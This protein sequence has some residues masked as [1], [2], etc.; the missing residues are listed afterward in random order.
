[1][2][3]EGAPWVNE[4]AFLHRPSKTLV[5]TDLVFNVHGARGLSPLVFRMVGAWKKLAQS[6][7]FRSQ[8]KDREAFAAAGRQILDWDFDAVLM[9]HGEPVTGVDANGRDPKQRLRAALS[10]MVLEGR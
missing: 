9:A 8:V 2:F 6:R 4:V 5:V 3:V 10:W 7:L 1:M